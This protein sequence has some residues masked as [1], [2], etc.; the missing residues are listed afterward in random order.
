MRGA[1]VGAV[2]LAAGAGQ[3]MGRVAKALLPF[4][5]SETFLSALAGALRRGG[6]A[7]PIL[8]VTGAH[9]AEVARAALAL[10]LRPVH[11]ARHAG[12]QFGSARRGLGAALRLGMP[13]VLLLPCDLP[14]LRARTVQRLLAAMAPAVPVRGGRTGHPLALDRASAIRLLAVSGAESLRE[15]M[16]RSGIRPRRVPVPDPAIHQ[17]LNT[18]RAYRRALTRAPAQA[19][20]RSRRPATSS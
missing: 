20:S 2:I 5:R 6:V 18:L 12:G 14:G 4:G 16:R 3:R 8:V 1:G 13:A 9:R 17:N 7:G 10:G 19:K 15:A 11:N